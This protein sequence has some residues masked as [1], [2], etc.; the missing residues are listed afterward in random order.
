MSSVRVPKQASVWQHTLTTSTMK[1]DVETEVEMAE[2]CTSPGHAP[3]K[4]WRSSSWR[5]AAAAA[6][7]VVD[8]TARFH[9][10]GVRYKAKLIGTDQV[11][12]AQGDKMCLDSM[13]K[14]K[15]SYT[16]FYIKMANTPLPSN[17]LADIFNIKVD[18]P[19][20]ANQIAPSCQPG[21]PLQPLSKDQIL[22]NFSV[23]PVGGSPSPSPTTMG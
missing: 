7:V 2:S 19:A 4:T 12:E 5:G 22:S 1:T 6:K 21:S 10:D 11:V 23:A 20:A 15:S 3:I 16:L 14:L 18:E 17:E 8:P 13:M 9:G